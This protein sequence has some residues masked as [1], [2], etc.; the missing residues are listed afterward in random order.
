[1]KKNIRDI[2]EDW[3]KN[4]I[5]DDDLA[6]LLKGTD[7]ARYSIVKRALKAG[8]LVHMRKG[9]YLIASK[10]KRVLPDEFELSLLIYEPSIISLESALSYHG[11]IPEAVYTTTCATPKRAQEFETPIGFYSYKHVPEQGFYVGVARIAT[12]TGIFLVADPWRA[13]AD[14]MYTRRRSWENLSQLE[15]DLRID[16]DTAMEGDKQLLKELSENYPSPRVRKV[17]KKFLREITKNSRV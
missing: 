6:Q 13:L 4:Y 16:V 14:F 7:D 15:A 17:L 10:I 9:L 12:Q 3:P 8:L 1:M 5:R 2:F 11:W